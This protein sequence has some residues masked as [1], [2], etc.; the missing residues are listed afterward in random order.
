MDISSNI[1]LLIT[2][3]H[4]ANAEL[5]EKLMET[6]S[7]LN[8]AFETIDTVRSHRAQVYKLYTGEEINKRLY[9]QTQSQLNVMAAKIIECSVFGSRAE[10]R[11]LAERLRLLSR[12]EEKSL[13]THL[14]SHGQAIR[15]LFY[16]CDTAMVTCIGKNQT[17][18]QT[19]N[20]R[21]QAVMEAVEALTQYR[22]SLTTYRQEY[23]T[24]IQLTLRR[25]GTLISKIRNFHYRE[26]ERPISLDLAIEQLSNSLFKLANKEVIK[27][28][29][30][31]L[32]TT[33]ISQQL[34]SVY[35]Q[36]I[37]D[38]LLSLTDQGRFKA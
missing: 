25:G 22:L 13:A 38:S 26:I 30:L 10:R 24:D 18:L 4:E 5:S 2:S 36:V 33:E 7:A 27:P 31:Y 20:E 6:Q 1:L 14:V 17:S 21:W 15:N 29:E 11:L 8:V 19:Y 34:I 23:K 32:D 9:E 37:T 3:M 12:H 16:A 35:H 28:A